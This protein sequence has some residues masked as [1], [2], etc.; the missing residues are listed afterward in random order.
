MTVK[1]LRDSHEATI[2]DDDQ[3]R[4]DE[5]LTF[6]FR[7]R[8]LSAPQIDARMDVWFGD[9]PN[10]D[11]EV[12]KEFADDVERASAG[13]LNHWAHE[14][15]GRLALILLIDQFRRKTSIAASPK[16]SRR[17]RRL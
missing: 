4:I 14:P 13:E 15:R 1:L 11:A 12:K 8:S 2:T 16:H 3:I 9:D 6:W 10:F 17:T 5:V 7:E